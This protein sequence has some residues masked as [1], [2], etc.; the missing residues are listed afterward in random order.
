MANRDDSGR[1]PVCAPSKNTPSAPTSRRDLLTGMAAIGGLAVVPV[2]AF[3]SSALNGDADWLAAEREVLRLLDEVRSGAD[4]ATLDRY[5]HAWTTVD[6]A[7][8]KAIPR[9]PIQA[10]TKMRRVL[11]K[12][13][14]VDVGW[15]PHRVAMRQIEAFLTGL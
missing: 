7:I 14:G 10:A 6:E 4:D 12:S 2:S 9:T 8:L 15:E 3:V 13:Q 11:C 1:A 5:Y